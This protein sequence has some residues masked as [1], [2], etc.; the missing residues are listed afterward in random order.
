MKPAAPVTRLRMKPPVWQPAVDSLSARAKASARRMTSLLRPDPRHR[1][2]TR[3]DDALVAGIAAAS[4][5][6]AALADCE[7]AGFGPADLVLCAGLGVATVLAGAKSRRWTWLW[8]AGA[9]AAAAPDL[10]TAVPALVALGLALM[11]ASVGGR[12]RALGALVAGLALQTLLRL[13]LADPHGLATLV[14]VAALLPLLVSGYKRSRRLTRRIVWIGILAFAL[15]SVAAAVAQGIAVAQAE[16]AVAD[17]IDAAEA[18]FDAARDGEEQPAVIAFLQAAESFDQANGHLTQ[19][20]AWAGRFVPI[21]GQHARAMSEITDAGTDLATTAAES[22]HSAPLDELEFRDGVLD[23]E[24]VAQFV[25]PVDQAAAALQAADEV[26]A[27]VDSPWLLAPLADRV[28]QFADEVGEARPQAELAQAGVAVAPGLFGGDEPRQYFLAFT[29]PAELRGLDGF[30]GNYGILTAEDGDL[31]LARSEEI[32]VFEQQLRAIEAELRGPPDYVSRYEPF[33]LAHAP[34]DV[35]LSPD[36]PSVAEVIDG[37]HRQTLGGPLDG[38]ILVDPYALE[39]LLTFTG[40]IEIPDAPAPLTSENAA[41]FLLREQ[42]VSFPDR[43]SRKD[44]LSDAAEVTFD[45]LTEGDI[46]GPRRVT[47]VLGPMVDQGRLAVYS[48]HDDEQAFFEQAGI[49]GAFPDAQGGDLIGIT[50]QNTAHNKGDGFLRRSV[51]YRATVDPETGAVEATATVTLINDAPSSGLPE[52]LIG[53]P[54]FPGFP[55]L[56]TGTNRMLLSLYS[57]LGLDGVRRGDLPL[58]VRSSE[59]LGVNVYSRFVVVPPGS[60]ATITFDLSG[61]VD[62]EDGYRLAVPHQPT[63]NPDEITT[64]ITTADGWSLDPVAGFEGS[65]RNIRASWTS[66]TD[67]FLRAEVDES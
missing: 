42:Y 59:E 65:G 23:L 24:Q 47:S 38:V 52:I 32:R 3:V 28:D 11:G 41:E 34:G 8:M 10:A 60:R 7:P 48:F 26:V 27:Q 29:T 21:L 45:A 54:R 61:V 17:G 6:G 1:A 13:D 30:M 37:F 51:D 46:P 16:S 44:F 5:V 25:D 43:A 53:V 40:P 4:A 62:L 66:E 67:R 33:N 63:I 9:A 22:A 36:F 14:A 56:P 50:S 49:D 2:P 35:T 20:W 55:V 39:A 19:P 57:P 31:E 12:S 18:G 58:S 64:E 15:F